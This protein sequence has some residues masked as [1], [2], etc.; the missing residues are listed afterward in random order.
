M[1]RKGCWKKAF[2][3]DNGGRKRLT[4]NLVPGSLNSNKKYLDFCSD[5]PVSSKKTFVPWVVD[6]SSDT[7]CDGADCVETSDKKWKNPEGGL[8]DGPGDCTWEVET[9]GTWV[10]PQGYWSTVIGRWI[11]T[12]PGVWT[13]GTGTWTCENSKA[14]WYDRTTWNC[15]HGQY[16]VMYDNPKNPNRKKEYYVPDTDTCMGGGDGGSSYAAGNCDCNETYAFNGTVIDTN[17]QTTNKYTRV[18][19][20][21]TNGTDGLWWT[22]DWC[23]SGSANCRDDAI[24]ATPRKYKDSTG[25]IFDGPGFEY[26]SP[27]GE[28]DTQFQSSVEGPY[29]VSSDPRYT[30]YYWKNYTVRP[31]MGAPDD[32]DV[33]HDGSYYKKQSGGLAD[34]YTVIATSELQADDGTTIPADSVGTAYEGD[35]G[36]AFV[37]FTNGIITYNAQSTSFSNLQDASADVSYAQIVA[38]VISAWNVKDPQ[39]YTLS[40]LPGVESQPMS[41]GPI[42]KYG[43]DE[44]L[45]DQMDN[46]PD[47]SICD[48]SEATW[49]TGGYTNCGGAVPVTGWD[50]SKKDAYS[51][52]NT[53]LWDRSD[54]TKDAFTY[55]LSDDAYETELQTWMSENCYE[56]DGVTLL[57]DYADPGPDC[58]VC[59]D[60]DFPGNQ[61]D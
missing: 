10:P 19:C 42:Y 1:S 50:D 18:D 3:G 61:E 8:E 54:W 49:R 26:K 27:A 9:P 15:G 22:S 7:P 23:Q 59:D 36:S 14:T 57:A 24:A 58:D 17:E 44:A 29:A 56:E 33:Y 12:A 5:D 34:G 45:L 51:G 13:P 4:N 46:L 25:A 21:H 43:D 39:Y 28:G 2:K 55:E 35:D 40:N 37:N 16:G 6:Q 11:Q 32:Y 53:T 38:E 31:E 48:N 41:M 60:P 47:L 30:T 20:P 52:S